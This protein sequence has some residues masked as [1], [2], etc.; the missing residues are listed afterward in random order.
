[1]KGTNRITFYNRVHALVSSDTDFRRGLID[2]ANQIRSN[3]YDYTPEA[4]AEIISRAANMIPDVVKREREF[5]NKRQTRSG[6]ERHRR[7][8]KNLLK[9][10]EIFIE[11]AKELS[12]L[13]DLF[14]DNIPDILDDI[15]SDKDFNEGMR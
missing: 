5:V 3:P 1:M 8:I 13:D 12:L 15:Q 11:V 14:T 9:R 4:I 10:G 7:E 2:F 6:T